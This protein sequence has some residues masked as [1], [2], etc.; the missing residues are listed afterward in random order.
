MK[1][2]LKL[3]KYIEYVE[4]FEAIGQALKGVKAGQGF[5]ITKDVSIRGQRKLLLISWK[6]PFE[7]G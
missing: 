6:E 1:K 5:T 7:E 2:L 4:L 3:L